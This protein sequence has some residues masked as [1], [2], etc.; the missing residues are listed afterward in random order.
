MDQPMGHHRIKSKLGIAQQSGGPQA[1][2]L[3]KISNKAVGFIGVCSFPMSPPNPRE[4]S[5]KLKA[6]LDTT[7]PF[8]FPKHNII[9]LFLLFQNGEKVIFTAETVAQQKGSHFCQT[10]P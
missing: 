9:V 8:R 3:T 10:C 5:L 4:L 7:V 6:Y 2:L 1:T